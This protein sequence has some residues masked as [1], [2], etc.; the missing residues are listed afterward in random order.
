MPCRCGSIRT[1]SRNLYRHAFRSRQMRDRVFRS[2][3]GPTRPV[4]CV[5]EVVIRLST[6][7]FCSLSNISCAQVAY[8]FCAMALLIRPSAGE[9]R[10]F[11][12]E[13]TAGTENGPEQ[14]GLRESAPEHRRTRRFNTGVRL[15]LVSAFTGFLRARCVL[16][17]VCLSILAIPQPDTTRGKLR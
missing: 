12:T 14:D 9:G 8:P 11:T 7:P 1:D 10:N 5:D 17:G 2:K 4:P 13:D 16:R 6:H 15:P 3:T